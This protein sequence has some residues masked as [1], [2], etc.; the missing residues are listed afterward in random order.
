MLG[1]LQ[2]FLTDQF[3]KLAFHPD[4]F[5][6]NPALIERERGWS[7]QNPPYMFRCALRTHL[8]PTIPAARHHGFRLQASRQKMNIYLHFLSCC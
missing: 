6:T 5:R 1:W 3:I 8:P 4:T 7:N 2:P